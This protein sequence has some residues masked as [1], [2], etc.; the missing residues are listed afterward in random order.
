[1]TDSIHVTVW[2]RQSYTDGKQIRGRTRLTV[3]ERIWLKTSS[4]GGSGVGGDL[5][6]ETFCI[7]TVGTVNRIMHLS[8]PTEL[9]TR[10][11]R[12]YHM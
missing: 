5:E 6:G 9:Y 7:L 10:E 12:F 11:T 3:P 8:K 1:M 2:K 4:A